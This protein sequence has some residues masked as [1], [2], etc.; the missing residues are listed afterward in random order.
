MSRTLVIGSND[1]F[2]S[3]ITNH[4]LQYPTDTLELY[5]GYLGDEFSEER[6]EEVLTAL[7][8]SQTAE[9]VVE[10]NL[11]GRSDWKI[12]SEKI[13]SLF[14]Q[15]NNLIGL[16]LGNHKLTEISPSIGRL[17][18]LKQLWLDA[19]QLSK[20]PEELFQLEQL[21]LLSLSDNRIS[22]LSPSIGRLVKLKQL[23]LK[24]N[25]LVSLPVIL[26]QLPLEELWVS[27][28]LVVCFEHSVVVMLI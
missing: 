10:I 17:V 7:V 12:I 8:A 28:E 25:Q 13:W 23:S 3:K 1:D 18:K 5:V 9:L 6:I 11:Y 19:N 26:G 15:I 24:N 22:S 16:S 21:E 20:L 27:G 2:K 14:S 4:I